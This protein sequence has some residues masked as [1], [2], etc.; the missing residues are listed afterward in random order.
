MFLIKKFKTLS[1][2]RIQK[3]TAMT[4]SYEITYFPVAALADLPRMIFEMAKADYKYNTV[5]FS[6][7]CSRLL[8]DFIILSN[9]GSDSGK[10]SNLVLDT[11]IFRA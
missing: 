7:A 9:D 2:A 1:P 5:Q 8:S 4:V 11:D 3:F 10:R 6:N